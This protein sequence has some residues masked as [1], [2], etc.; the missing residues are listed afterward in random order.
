MDERY[1]F[2]ST[3]EF[4]YVCDELIPEGL[5]RYYER[6]IYLGTELYEVSK[7][8]T[9]VVSVTA[10]SQNPSVEPHIRSNTRFYGTKIA[11]YSVRTGFR[12]LSMF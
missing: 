11:K 1:P 12:G 7:K 10:K 6:Q 5:K 8:F 4:R 3:E 2:N 9:L